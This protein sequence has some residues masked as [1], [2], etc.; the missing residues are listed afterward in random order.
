MVRRRP[1]ALV[2]G[3]F[4]GVPAEAD[5]DVTRPPERWSRVAIDFASESVALHGSATAVPSRTLQVTAAAV[6][7]HTQGSSVRM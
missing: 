6:P 5:A 2:V 4:L 7:S 3:E 1:G